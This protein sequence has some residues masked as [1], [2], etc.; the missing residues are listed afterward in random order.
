MALY[1]LVRDLSLRIDGYELVRRARAL[2]DRHPRLVIMTGYGQAEDRER[3]FAA[4]CDQHLTKPVSLEQ[5][6]SAIR[7]VASG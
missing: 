7:Q 4:G 3:A 6:E 5:L 1:D 2:P